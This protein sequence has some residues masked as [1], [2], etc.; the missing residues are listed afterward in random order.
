[1]LRETIATIGL[2]FA[3]LM[4]EAFAAPTRPTD[5]NLVL[6]TVTPGQ[7]DADSPLRAAQTALARDPKN[8]E[9]AVAVARIGIEEG[10]TRGDPRMYGQAQAALMP[11]WKQTDP[12]DEIQVLRAVILQSFHDFKGAATDLDAI[13]KRSPANAQARLSRAFIRMVTGDPKPAQ[14]DCNRLPRG[15]D[16]IVAQICLARVEALTGE[17]E[18]AFM[19][20]KRILAFKARSD[21]AMSRF[22]FVVMADIAVGLGRNADADALYDQAAAKGAPD[23]S[24]LAAHADLLLDLDRPADALAVLDGRGEVDVLILRRAIAAKRI[25]DPRVAEWSAILSERFAAAK[26]GGVSVHLREDARFRLEILEDAGEAL[27]LARANWEV[28]REPADAHLLVECALA[29]GQPNAANDVK[30]FVARTGI[31]DARINQALER[32]AEKR[33]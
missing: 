8:L 1:M 7:T 32:L 10:R 30:D 6:A 18:R 3:A 2:L 22:A 11:W 20:L 26:L 31:K 17:G 13:L 19:R 28:Q 33:S 24:L 12:P 15:I 16:A 23:V 14:E 25:G 5:D 9:L 27:A 29:A 21:S 4:P